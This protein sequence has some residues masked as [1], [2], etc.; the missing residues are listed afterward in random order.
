MASIDLSRSA[1]DPR[2]RYDSLR[3]Q[4]GVVLDEDDFN[5]NERIDHEDRRRARVEFVGPAGSP[6]DGFRIDNP[7]VDANGDINFD[8][9]AGSFYLGGHRL[10]RRRLKP[11]VL[12]AIGSNGQPAPIRRPPP[13]G[14]TLRSC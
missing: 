8:I 2:K 11:S 5:E 14:L 3:M 10:N 13:S 9:L 1:F 12:S 7:Q 4:L 6:D